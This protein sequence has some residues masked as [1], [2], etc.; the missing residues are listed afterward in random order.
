MVRCGV[1]IRRRAGIV[2]LTAMAAGSCAD[3]G[4]SCP[5][6]ATV[7]IAATG[8]PPSLLPPLVYETVG[9]DI[10]DLV[11]ERLATLA[12]EGAPIDTAAYRP[13]LAASWE[14]VDSLSWRFHLR[15]NARWHDGRPVTAEDVVFSFE[16][17]A[18]SAVGAVAQ[19]S[20]AGQVTASAA[21]DSTVLV[22][23]RR[24]GAEQLYDAT[25]HV[26]VLPKHVW[27]SIPR[28][29]WPADTSLARLVGSGPYRPVAWIRGQHFILAA[30]TAGKQPPEIRRL[31]WRFARDADAA[32][33]LVLAHEADLMES[34]G[35]PDRVARVAGDSS[36]R[37][38]SYPAANY[39]F[40][41]F[42]HR[43]ARGRPHPTLSRREVRRGLTAALD[44]QG[45]AR[46]FLGPETKVPPG[47][48]SQLLWI[49]SED[50]DVLEFDSAAARPLLRAASA[51]RPIDILVPSTSPSRRQFAQAIQEAWRRAGVPS[52]VTAVDFPVFQERLAG[53]RFDAFIGA[54]GDEPSPRGLA[55]QWSRSGWGVLNHG[56]Y[57][58]PSFDSLLAAAAAARDVSSARRLWHQA[59]DTL[60]ADA[61]AIF[62]YAPVNVA[63][64]HRR[65]ENVSIDPFSWLSGVP[66]WGVSSERR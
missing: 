20:I 58:N 24:S 9:R 13:G 2:W 15:P 27:D 3:E 38:V 18:D 19:S 21:D 14:R 65:L 23:F 7:V 16:A 33:S 31:I 46:A 34:I 28:T 53:G 49:W 47:P 44:R 41:A 51:G 11:F 30:D 57:A 22:R 26:R 25:Y 39:G 12:P 63:A 59:M 52:T 6:C 62:L 64:V 17:Y 54:Y 1:G 61:A 40:L 56:R 36:Y 66:D 60:N 50:L 10:V 55:D 35:T 32:L 45:F 43:D 29:E 42:R 5:D 8:E 37:A 4:A 48:M